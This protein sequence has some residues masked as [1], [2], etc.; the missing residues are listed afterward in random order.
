VSKP[1]VA[2]WDAIYKYVIACGGDDAAGLDSQKETRVNIEREIQRLLVS[3]A[4][5]TLKNRI[6]AA[7]DNRLVRAGPSDDGDGFDF[8]F[9]SELMGEVFRCFADM[10]PD[11]MNCVEIRFKDRNKREGVL[12]ITRGGKKSPLTL[13]AEAVDAL[14]VLRGEVLDAGQARPVSAT[15]M[16]AAERV[17][18]GY[19]AAMESWRQNSP[20]VD[21]PGSGQSSKRSLFR[22]LWPFCNRGVAR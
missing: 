2:L 19:A 11:G 15:A 16:D 22:R 17:I 7:C 6:A 8:V 10:V 12:S 3:E 21:A 18:A 13:R 14:L 20:P 9:S 5:A 1:H 4:D